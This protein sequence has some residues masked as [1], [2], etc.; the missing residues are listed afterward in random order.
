MSASEQALK[1][2]MAA[3]T[4]K[5]LSWP[6][7]KAGT[8]KSAS[9]SCVERGTCRL[10]QLDDMFAPQ[11]AVIDLQVERRECILNRDGGDGEV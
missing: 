8:S 4:I 11:V 6:M 1:R 9:S 10:D 7:L 5:R 3:A 2:N